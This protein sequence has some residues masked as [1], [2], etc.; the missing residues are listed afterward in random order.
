MVY[1]TAAMMITR[2]GYVTL[3]ELEARHPKQADAIFSWMQWSDAKNFFTAGSAFG[4][5]T[6]YHLRRELRGLTAQEITRQIYKYFHP[7]K[8]EQQ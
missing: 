2:R 5:G 1:N 6:A 4:G 8:T 3:A 7:N